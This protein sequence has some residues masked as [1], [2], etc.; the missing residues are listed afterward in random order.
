MVG[1]K[2][3]TNSCPTVLICRDGNYVPNH[4]AQDVH[5]QWK[6]KLLQ[7]PATIAKAKWTKAI[8]ELDNWLE[9][10]R[11]QPQLWQDLISGL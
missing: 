2:I 5:A 6:T 8:E 11:T 9:A 7:C 10:T 3:A 1:L 4:N